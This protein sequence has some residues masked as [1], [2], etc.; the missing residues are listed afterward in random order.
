MR[1]HF[2]KLLKSNFRTFKSCKRYLL[3]ATTK[4]KLNAKYEEILFNDLIFE[5][6]RINLNKE[7]DNNSTS[8]NDLFKREFFII[9]NKLDELLNENNEL[10]ELVRTEENDDLVLMAKNDLITSNSL[11][12]KQKANL[13]DLIV[14]TSLLKNTDNS[15]TLIV[16]VFAGVGGQEAMLFTNELFEMY[17][18]FSQQNEFSFNEIEYETTDLGGI[19]HAS[20]EINGYNVYDVLKYEAGVHRVQRVP[21]TERTGRLHTSTSAVLILPKLA[22]IEINISQKDLKIEACKSQGPG[23]QHVN[24]TESACRLTHIPTNLVV[25]CQDNRQFNQNKKRAMEILEYKLY[26]LKCDENQEIVTQTKKS[27]VSDTARSERIRTYNFP[28][29]RITDHRLNDNIFNIDNF[30]S[31]NGIKLISDSLK[32]EEKIKFLNEIL[33]RE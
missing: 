22:N 10:N 13:L 14:Q 26:K 2:I 16:E 21:K 3:L 19:R 1:F 33:S 5:K 32:T 17:K 25:F 23:G 15:N 8:I 28:Q 24:K 9:N 6:L 29:D 27:Q 31:G 7:I 20:A 4:Q 18:L 12:L 30:M 11:I